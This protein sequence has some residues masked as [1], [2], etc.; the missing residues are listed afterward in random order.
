MG[1]CI[2]KIIFRIIKIV[3]WHWTNYKY[4][5]RDDIESDQ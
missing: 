5:D 3:Q 1:A 2:N 4:N